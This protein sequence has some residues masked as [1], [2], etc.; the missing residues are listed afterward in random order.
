MEYDVKR[1]AIGEGRLNYL[2]M[3]SNRETDRFIRLTRTSGICS[4]FYDEIRNKLPF[5]Y[6]SKALK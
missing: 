2:D 6:E 5:L 1:E 3:L 4:G